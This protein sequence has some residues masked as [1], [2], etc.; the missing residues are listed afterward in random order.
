MEDEQCPKC[1]SLFPAERAWAYRSVPSLMVLGSLS[2]LDTRVRCPS[3]GSVFQA[4]AARFL[5]FL[6][7][8]AMRWLVATFIVG[9]FVAAG[10]FVLFL[11]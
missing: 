5:G 4:T 8:R 9:G 1:G 10:Y 6:T 2:D 7:P 3:C 11:P